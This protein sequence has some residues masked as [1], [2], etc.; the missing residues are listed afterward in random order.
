MTVHSEPSATDDV[1]SEQDCRGAQ[2][3]VVNMA[4]DPLTAPLR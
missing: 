1:L 2:A 4:R 3:L